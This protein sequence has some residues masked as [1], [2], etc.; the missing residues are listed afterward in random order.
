MKKEED[1][2]GER[3]T[4][5]HGEGRKQRR[6][7]EVASSSPSPPHPSGDEITSALSASGHEG[8]EMRRPS[9]SPTRVPFSPIT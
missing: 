7:T 4:K 3:S 2:W 9:L 6:G 5:G 8:W 1:G